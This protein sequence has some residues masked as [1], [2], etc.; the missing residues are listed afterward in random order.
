[1][2]KVT[3]KTIEAAFKASTFYRSCETS[4]FLWSSF[5]CPCK[6]SMAKCGN[7]INV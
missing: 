7:G 6:N 4:W 5:N 3:Q 1:M 2:E